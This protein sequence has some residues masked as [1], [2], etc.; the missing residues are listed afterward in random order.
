MATKKILVTVSGSGAIPELGYI[1]APIVN[2]CR[3]DID[4]VSKMVT[5]GRK[6]YAVNPNNPNER[7]LLTPSTVYEDNFAKKETPV[8]ASAPKADKK[9]ETK[10]E[11][12]PETKAE[13]K[14]E[15]VVEKTDKQ[16][17]NY[18]KSSSKK[19]KTNEPKAT[20]TPDASADDFFK[21]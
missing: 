21:K 4:K 3:L 17:K 15:P 11:P 1:C 7:V 18:N 5:A 6:V 2:P 14:T 20:V 12:V 13:T 9:V 10:P 16:E 8:P 19:D